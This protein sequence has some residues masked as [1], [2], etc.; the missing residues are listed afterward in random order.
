MMATDHSAIGVEL[1]AL[2]TEEEAP[3][4]A[5]GGTIERRPDARPEIILAAL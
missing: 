5:A 2:K 1:D 3:V 4:M